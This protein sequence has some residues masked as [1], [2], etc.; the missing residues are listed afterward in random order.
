[1][2]SISSQG[3]TPNSS[4]ASDHKDPD[5]WSTSHEDDGSDDHGMGDSTDEAP[6]VKEQ[7]D[8]NVPIIVVSD[9]AHK[10]DSEVDGSTSPGSHETWR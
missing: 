8:S 4:M 10:T 7:P 5:S 3:S 2:S 6:K 9:D 1:M